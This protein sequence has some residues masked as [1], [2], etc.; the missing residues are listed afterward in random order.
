MLK[1][2]DNEN[3]ISSNELIESACLENI[4]SDKHNNLSLLVGGLSS[5]TG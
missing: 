1:A 3:V 4:L 2:A 5:L